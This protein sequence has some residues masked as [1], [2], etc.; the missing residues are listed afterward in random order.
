[1]TRVERLNRA[2][3]FLNCLSRGGSNIFWN[4]F[5]SHPDACSP[6]RETLEI[7]RADWRAPTRTGL[8]LALTSGQ[9]RLFEL[10][11]ISPRYV[12]FDRAWIHDLDH[13]TERRSD[14][15]RSLV[16]M[17]QGFKI[18]PIAEG[19]ERHEEAEACAE[20]GFELAQGFFLGRPD[21]ASE[22]A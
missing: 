11:E 22:L 14:L 9:P 8:W 5:L 13:A 17:V 10:A 18:I 16:R 20:L 12:K 15:V 7:F 2:P 3:I 21:R 6:I 19:V 4:L 1:M